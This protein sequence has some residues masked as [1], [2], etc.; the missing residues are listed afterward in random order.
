MNAFIGIVLVL[1]IAVLISYLVGISVKKSNASRIDDLE[2]RKELL[3]DLP[4]L[5]EVDEVKRMHLVGESQKTFREWNQKWLILSTELFADVEHSIYEVETLNGSFRWIKANHALVAAENLIATMEQEVL[6]LREDLKG[7]RETEER[8]SMLVQ[9]ALDAYEELKTKLI[10]E[11]ASFGPAYAKMQEALKEVEVAFVK[12]VE[13]NSSG[14]P[15]EASEILADAERRTYDLQDVVAVV[16]GLF[17]D[18][19]VAFPAQV[20]ELK[21]SY[22]KLIEQKY[23][24]PEGDFLG[25]V[26]II[27]DN[28][29]ETTD[30]LQEIDNDSIAS[31]EENNREIASDIDG[32]YEVLEI[33]INAKKYVRSNKSVIAA[34]I[35]HIKENNRQLLIE[36]DHVSQKYVLNKN[37][38]SQ[39]KKF[40]E[41]IEYL[42]ERFE[43]IQPKVT[44][45]EVPYSEVEDLYHELFDSLKEMEDKQ[46][47]IERELVQLGRDEKKA[48]KAQ[49]EFEFELRN[50]KRYVQKQRVPG[51][52]SE[53]LEFF[54]VATRRVEDLYD[55]LNRIRVNMDEIRKVTAYCKEDISLLHEKTDTLVRTIHITEQLIQYANRYRHQYDFMREA[56]EHSYNLWAKKFA[57]KEAYNEI[58]HA[59]ENIE[60][61][62]VARIENFY[63]NNSEF[64]LE[65]AG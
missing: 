61:G 41:R 20:E 9:Q 28:I 11:E 58:A 34:F 4:I 7:L 50:I 30:E 44:E 14:D 49:A 36:L 48:I 25:D 32:L 54:N 57:Y 60:P 62:A 64:V 27:E 13:K 40:S 26:A 46:L 21:E 29:D 65:I 53:Y 42:Q 5:E 16:P 31:V 55:E 63:D 56:V 23:V 43:A 52:P 33:E 6:S 24:F 19:K 59:L 10:E 18:L 8:N 45:H 12:F 39:T 22:N 1:V 17:N 47:T 15:V 35:E 2:R 3:F 37:E 51:L 38:I